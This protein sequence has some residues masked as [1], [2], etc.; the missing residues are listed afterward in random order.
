MSYIDLIDLNEKKLDVNLLLRNKN[1]HGVHLDRLFPDGEHAKLLNPKAIRE[2]K[3]TWHLVNEGIKSG[4]VQP[5]PS[6]VFGHE[7][8]ESAF[9]FMSTGKHI[10][11]VV[12]QFGQED[13]EEK[14]L[15]IK[16]R[17]VPKSYFDPKKSYII[18][19]GLGG[20]G[21]ELMFWMTERGAKNFVLTSRSGVKTPTHKFM[22]R[23]VTNSGCKVLVSTNDGGNDQGALKVVKEA[24]S[25]GPIGGIFLSTLVLANESID[26]I[27]VPMYE[28]VMYAKS[29]QAVV[30]DRVL[31]KL[32]YPIDYFVGFSSIAA[33]RGFPGQ[34]N[35]AFANSIVE[36]VCEQRRKDGLHG[37]AVQWG[38]IG[39][40]GYVADHV[41]VKDV[42]LISLLM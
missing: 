13:S 40:V 18:A 12:V 22:I 14:R 19:G 7:S 33:G 36:R 31:R 11:K 39:D 42:S 3:Q 15:P 2:R 35:Y 30:F 24:E 21:L 8:I 34:T 38:M 10:G 28:K 6:T 37:I 16:V 20:M 29:T 25:M 27:T 32:S 23:M 5:L 17:A 26:K 1:F 4:V 9:R 41:E